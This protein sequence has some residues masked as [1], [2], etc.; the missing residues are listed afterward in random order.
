M[1]GLLRQWLMDEAEVGDACTE[2]R[3]HEN[4]SGGTRYG[5]WLRDGPQRRWGECCSGMP[6][7]SANGPGP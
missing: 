4:G 2:R 5:C 1:G 7:P 3:R 6:T